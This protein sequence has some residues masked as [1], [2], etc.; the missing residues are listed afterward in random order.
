MIQS[1]MKYRIQNG[2]TIALTLMI[3]ATSTVAFAQPPG[4]VFPGYY[5]EDF[6]GVGRIVRIED[7]KIVINDQLYYLSPRVAYHT[8]SQEYAYKSAFKP[9]MLVGYVTG[10]VNEIVSM[11]FLEK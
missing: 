10:S 4:V 6:S 5:P 8:L 1:R 7:K 3:L 11:Y 2:L 9:G